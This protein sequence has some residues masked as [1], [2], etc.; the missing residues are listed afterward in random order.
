[1]NAEF[2]PGKKQKL[3]F[4]FLTFDYLLA[5]NTSFYCYTRHSRTHKYTSEVHPKLKVLRILAPTMTELMSKV[6]LW[7]DIMFLPLKRLPCSKGFSERFSREQPKGIFQSNLKV[8]ITFCSRR[9]SEKLGYVSVF[10]I[11]AAKDRTH[12]L[13]TFV[14]QADGRRSCRWKQPGV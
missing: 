7:L 8:C 3:S 6:I 11:D 9:L 5:S 12:G 13:V 14:E 10:R 2:I 4:L 1:M